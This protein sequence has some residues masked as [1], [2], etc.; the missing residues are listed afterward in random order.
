MKA[1]LADYLNT[2]A[3]LTVLERDLP[4][5]PIYEIAGIIRDDWGKV[6]YAAEPYLEAMEAL[7][8]VDDMYGADRGKSVIAY[9][10]GNS[11]SWRG[12]IARLVKKE[13]NKRIRA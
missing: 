8:S 13:L 2:Q 3:E 6:N 10:L 4:L 5:M 12:P 1:E 9:F 11:N 7:A